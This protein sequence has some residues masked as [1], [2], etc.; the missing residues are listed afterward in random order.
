MSWHAAESV[1]ILCYRQAKDKAEEGNLQIQQ[2]ND[3]VERW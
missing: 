3:Q 2:N 1:S